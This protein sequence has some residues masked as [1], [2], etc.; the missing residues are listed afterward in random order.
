MDSLSPARAMTGRIALEIVA[1]TAAGVRAALANGADR[2]EL[3]SA[4]AIGGVTPSPGLMRMAA[5][6]AKSSGIKSSG[7]R[8]S[9]IPIRAMIR[10]R[11]GD[12]T[13]SPDELEVMRHD[14]EA[15]RAE[16]MAGVVFG[17][18]TQTG[19]LDAEALRMLCRYARVQGLEIALHRSFD[20]T[21]D[22]LAALDLAVELGI[23]TVL[24]SGGRRTA[25]E[26]VDV[27]KQLMERAQGRIE[28]LAGIGITP[29]TVDDIVRLGDVRSVH[30]SCTESVD[31]VTGNNNQAWLLGHLRAGQKD[32]AG[33]T[34]AAMR[35]ALNSIEST[36]RKEGRQ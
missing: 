26:G 27:L 6:A 9:G 1:D 25:R 13:Y 14:I 36:L 10:P 20:L 32:T 29:D 24:T 35:E 2:I 7:I 5:E 22:P 19:E 8:P 15:A 18:N 23:A 21:P 12:F 11:G 34:I 16:G 3:C 31:N 28:I 4:L 17:A 30:A 33:A